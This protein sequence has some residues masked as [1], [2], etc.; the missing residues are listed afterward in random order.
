MP[1]A[2]RNGT[3]PVFLPI[4]VHLA[5][6]RRLFTLVPAVDRAICR[7]VSFFGDDVNVRLSAAD[8]F[9]DLRTIARLKAVVRRNKH[10]ESAFTE[11]LFEHG[12]SGGAAMKVLRHPVGPKIRISFLD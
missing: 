7:A 11:Q 2:R 5:T 3:A 10:A 8:R 12:L 1:V 4:N 6:E 9:E